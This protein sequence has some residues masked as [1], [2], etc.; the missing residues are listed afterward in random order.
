MAETIDTLDYKVG[1]HD[2][3]IPYGDEYGFSDLIVPDDVWLKIS[4][5]GNEG[6]LLCPTCMCRRAQAIGLQTVSRFTSGPFSG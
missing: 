6:G 5:Y 3:S 1:C 4:P 2:C